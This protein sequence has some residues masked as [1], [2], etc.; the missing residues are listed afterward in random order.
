MTDDEIIGTAINYHIP[1][2]GSE[3]TQTMLLFSTYEIHETVEGAVQ[4]S[5]DGVCLNDI[6]SSY[7]LV[8]TKLNQVS[9]L[10]HP[11]YD[12]IFAYRGTMYMDVVPEHISHWK[13]YAQWL[14]Y[15]NDTEP[16]K[17][18]VPDLGD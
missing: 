1:L 5:S 11:V 6:L 9:T 18:V 13:K 10:S 15:G 12:L 16:A 2:T 7:Q 3:L 4:F 17:V 14:I 8:S